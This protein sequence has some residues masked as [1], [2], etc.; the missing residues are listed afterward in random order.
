MLQRDVVWRLCREGGGLC[1]FVCMPTR[2]GGRQAEAIILDAQQGSTSMLHNST[3]NR[4]R[5]ICLAACCHG[6]R[7][8]MCSGW[9]PKL[10][11]CFHT[12]LPREP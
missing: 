1:G 8:R 10:P 2:H 12:F 7:N 5:C 6:W 11:Y 4:V 9:Q 3:R